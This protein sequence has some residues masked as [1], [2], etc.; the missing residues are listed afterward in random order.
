MKYKHSPQHFKPVGFAADEGLLPLANPSQQRQRLLVE[1]STFPQKYQYFVID[2]LSGIGKIE[3]EVE[4]VLCFDEYLPELKKALHDE[5][6]VLHCTPCVNIFKQSA[7]IATSDSHNHRHHVSLD[8]YDAKHKREIYRV[9]SLHINDKQKTNKVLRPLFAQSADLSKNEEVLY[10][11]S[12]RKPAWQLGGDTGDEVFIELN[13]SNLDIQKP[14]LTLTA[15]VLATDRDRPHLLPFGGNRP[16]LQLSKQESGPYDLQFLTQPTVT[17]RHNYQ[18]E[19]SWQILAYLTSS[20]DMLSQGHR[21]VEGI[22]RLLRLANCGQQDEIALFIQHIIDV[23]TKVISAPLPLSG[24]L[25]F[26]TGTELTITL[27]RS[28]T[29]KT[30]FYP[31]G[32]VLSQYFSAHCTI[33]SFIQLRI[34]MQQVGEVGFWPPVFGQQEI[35]SWN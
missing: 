30:D 6:I 8:K 23:N 33:N 21:G 20:H 1:Y 24:E 15:E 18:H 7:D 9:L 28:S 14:K 12:L 19:A 4:L 32:C 31:L 10:W 3:N 25:C 5:S 34:T 35:M 2:K 16:K 27:S 29:A 17:R 26:V 13:E 11:Q 22:K